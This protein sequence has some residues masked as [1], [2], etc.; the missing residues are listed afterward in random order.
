MKI[1]L[2]LPNKN[3]PQIVGDRRGGRETDYEDP[4]LGTFLTMKIYEN[5]PMGH[6]CKP[7]PNR[8]SSYIDYPIPQCSICGP[9][10]WRQG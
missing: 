10:L 8:E 4:Q 2:K 6:F 1:E 3:L 5:S 7:L 9:E